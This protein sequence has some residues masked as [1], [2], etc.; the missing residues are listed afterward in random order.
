MADLD[1]WGLRIALFLAGATM[2]LLLSNIVR[3]Q[4]E[5]RPELPELTLT[6]CPDLAGIDV[7]G[8][9]ATFPRTTTDCMLGRLRLLPP[10]LR[11]VRLLEERLRLDDQRIA[12]RDREVALAVEQAELATANLETAF[13]RAR[14]AEEARDVWYRSPFL[15]LAV[16]V[17]LTVGLLVAGAYALSSIRP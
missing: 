15:W 5:E 13:R 8:D 14:E 3:A 12:L 7:S 10:I 1:R 11:Y 16:G 6:P 9:A 4:D 2:L 17:V